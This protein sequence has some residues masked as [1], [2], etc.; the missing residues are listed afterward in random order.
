MQVETKQLTFTRFI[1]AYLIVIF[2][3]GK[4]VFPF[5][6]KEIYFFFLNGNIAVSYFYIL[7]GFVMTIAYGNK[8][9]I[10]AKIFFINRIARIFP[11][12]YVSMFLFFIAII[13]SN[14]QIKPLIYILQLFMIQSWIPGYVIG[15]NTP[16]WSISVEIFFYALFPLLINFYYK[17]N[18]KVVFFGVL[19]IWFFSQILHQYLIGQFSSDKTL[20]EFVFYFPILH[21]NQFL[22]GNIFGLFFLKFS[23]K[24]YGN[25]DIVLIIL[26]ISI[27]FTLKFLLRLDFHNGLLAVLFAPFILLLACNNGFLTKIFSLKLFVFLGDISYGLYILQYPIF[28]F[29]RKLPIENPTLL[30]FVSSFIL[31]IVSI[32]S[33]FYIEKPFRKIIKK[34][35]NKYNENIKTNSIV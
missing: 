11:V 15:A 12:Y 30:F 17:K 3:F 18:I 13:I 33:Y 32:L 8:H 9:K 1:A 2:H 29:M 20:R 4:E 14:I 26:A 25:Y 6:R 28:L 35:F 31:F 16:S 24:I 7:S 10:S 5:F 19:L 23:H 27:V 22:M 21:L 34:Q